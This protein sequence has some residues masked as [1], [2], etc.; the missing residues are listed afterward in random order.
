MNKKKVKFYPINGKP[1]NI[2]T[3]D[4][5]TY[6]STIGDDQVLNNSFD[7]EKATQDKQC[8]CICHV[9][10]IAELVSGKPYDKTCFHCQPSEQVCNT[11]LH[12]KK[13]VTDKGESVTQGWEERFEELFMYD[14]GAYKEFSITKTG[15][16]G[17]LIDFIRSELQK[18]RDEID[19]LKQ[20]NEMLKRKLCICP[21][22]GTHTAC[23]VHDSSA[24]GVSSSDLNL[25]PT[26]HKSELKDYKGE[27]E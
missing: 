19:L 22:W 3:I 24:I 16:V 10:S 15:N 5:S 14:R 11:M 27:T 1:F 20:Q 7:V 9:M 12:N 17:T 4:E 23:P 21:N 2:G 26:L 13:N 8:D 18:Q 6:T 25:K